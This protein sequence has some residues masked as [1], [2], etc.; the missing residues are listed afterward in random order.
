[1]AKMNYDHASLS[2][3]IGYFISHYAAIPVSWIELASMYHVMDHQYW[4][5]ITVLDITHTVKV[6]VVER[7][8][9]IY[10]QAYDEMKDIVM[11]LWG[12]PKPYLM[13]VH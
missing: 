11:A 2:K 12:E 7:S 3:Y 10:E 9:D 13:A 5:R 1:M 4:V 6:N 8:T